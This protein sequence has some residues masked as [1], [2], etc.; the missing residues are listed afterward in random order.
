MFRF[1]SFRSGPD[2]DAGSVEDLPIDDEDGQKSEELGS[3]VKKP[4]TKIKEKVLMNSK[5]AFCD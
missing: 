2:S 1:L 3:K 4:H 5:Q